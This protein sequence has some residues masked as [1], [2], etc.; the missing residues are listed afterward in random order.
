[1]ACKS[2]VCLTQV[3]ALSFEIYAWRTKINSQ[4]LKTRQYSCG[5][6]PRP[7]QAEWLRHKQ[8]ALF[9]QAK[10]GA[11]THVHRHPLL[12]VSF[13]RLTLKVPWASAGHGVLLPERHLVPWGGHLWDGYRS[14]PIQPDRPAYRVPLDYEGQPCPFFSRM[15]KSFDRAG[16][17]RWQVVS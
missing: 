13:L 12:H 10:R 15:H 7:G 16:K 17:L 5:V 2:F 9:T 11:Y 6:E 4:G 3:V 14:T 1:M 8:A